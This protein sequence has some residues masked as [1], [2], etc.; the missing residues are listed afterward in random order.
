MWVHIDDNRYKGTD[1]MTYKRKK[2][3]VDSLP[4]LFEY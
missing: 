3:G 2:K 1:S 4:I